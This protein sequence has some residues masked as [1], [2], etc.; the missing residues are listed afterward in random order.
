MSVVIST[1]LSGITS[2]SDRIVSVLGQLVDKTHPI[3]LTDG[4][5]LSLK[6]DQLDGIAN[7]VDEGYINVTR[8]GGTITSDM[9]RN[10]SL[11]IINLEIPTVEKK[12]DLDFT[13]QYEV[14]EST[15]IV[16]DDISADRAITLSTTGV[17]DGAKFSIHRTGG[18]APSVAEV[19]TISGITSQ[20]GGLAGGEYFTLH[21]TTVDFYVWYDF[22]A[23]SE[24]ST[25]GCL[26]ANT[27]GSGGQYFT[28]SSATVD[29]YA[30]IYFAAAGEVTTISAITDAAGI[31]TG[32]YFTIH[33]TAVDYYVWMNKDAGGGDPTVP[34]Y[35]GIEVTVTTGD[36]AN[37]VATAI[38][39]AIDA[40][41]G[42]AVF[43][44]PVPGAD[45]IVITNL[46][47]GVVTHAADST[48][49][50][51]TG[52]TFTTTLAGHANT[53]DPAPGG[54]GIQVTLLHTDAANDVADKIAAA[55]HA[56]GGAGV[57]F[58]AANPPAAL[59]T[60][61]NTVAGATNAGAH[62]ADGLVP[63]GFALTTTQNGIDASVDPAVPAHTGIPVLI[64]LGD[65]ANDVAVKTAAAI[66]AVGGA[67]VFNVPV[68]AGTSIVVSNL[69][70]GA[71]ANAADG[72]GGAATNFTFTVTTP[73]YTTGAWIIDVGGLKNL[74]LDTWCEVA[75]SE[76][77]AA[78][79]LAE[80]GAL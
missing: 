21:S 38:A 37:T 20:A 70:A 69:V 44:V 40:V 25:I 16:E 73:G 63:T 64:A 78:W 14:N 19:T 53:I 2:T 67:A 34:A 7:M 6:E 66:D 58:T 60:C 23:V 26:A 29:Y 12:G 59:V 49:L 75:Y 5:Y 47:T 77:A 46:V 57:V 62:I 39:A 72:P 52:F 65:T 8:S 79:Y 42:A 9:L 33:S 13:L 30:W 61:I 41:G 55:L 71:V 22:A 17:L 15:I 74:A 80:Y 1:N 50:T 10:G 68:P 18:N 27:L 32:D 31:T 11:G 51:A 45:E 48:G 43:D 3:T 35:T 4:E 24:E 54:T 56:Q 76:T 28:L 36:D